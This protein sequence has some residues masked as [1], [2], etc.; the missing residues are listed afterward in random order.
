MEHAQTQWCS[1]VQRW[2]RIV[3]RE[4][5]IVGWPY[6]AVEGMEAGRVLFWSS[7]CNGFFAQLDDFLFQHTTTSK[8]PKP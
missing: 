4:V 5:S 2:L 3:A 8:N 7:V 1:M 6:L